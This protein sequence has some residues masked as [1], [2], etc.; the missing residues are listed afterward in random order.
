MQELR[1][2]LIKLDFGYGLPAPAMGVPRDPAYR[3]ERQH[4]EMIRLIATAARSIDPGVRIMYY[5][6]SPLSIHQVDIISLDDQGDLWYDIAG[7]HGEWSVWASLLSDKQVAVSGSSGYSWEPDDEVLLNTAIIGCPGATLPITQPDGKPVPEKYLNRRL[8][9]NKW[10]R[11][12]LIWRPLWINSH[13]GNFDGPPRLSCWGRMEDTALTALV[14]R[15]GGPDAVP[16]RL[17]QLS[18]KGR[19]AL[20]SQ[21]D[22]D[23][24]STPALAIIPFDAGEVVIPCPSKPAGLSRWNIAGTSSY[25][26]WQWADGRLTIKVTEDMLEHTAGFLVR[27][28]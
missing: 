1:P 15:E 8:A 10:Y 3:G 28:N 13:T 23:I 25:E 5:G 4:A 7:G 24:L 11:R 27:R 12:T 16:E 9:L 6:I 19:W 22:K 17:R 21:D 26:G 20:I 2:S 18:W 14:L